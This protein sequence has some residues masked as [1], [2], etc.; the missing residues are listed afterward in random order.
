MPKTIIHP[1][2]RAC[3]NMAIT[4]TTMIRPGVLAVLIDIAAGTDY[5]SN[6][7]QRDD[8]V[9]HLMIM[10]VRMRRMV[11]MVKM[12]TVM[13]TMKNPPEE[14]ARAL[15]L[16]GSVA[17]VQDSEFSAPRRKHCCNLVMMTM[18]MIMTRLLVVMM[19]MMMIT[20]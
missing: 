11:K 18:T 7:Q 5:Y 10:R 6:H 12:V 1:T 19:M 20:V 17:T 13:M 9:E 8:C 16:S 2:L 3:N 4:I 14:L 15:V